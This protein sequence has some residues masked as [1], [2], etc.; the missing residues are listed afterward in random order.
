MNLRWLWFDH[1]PR[2]LIVPSEARWVAWRRPWKVRSKS[3]FL[4][5]TVWKSL[6]VYLTIAFAPFAIFLALPLGIALPDW[7][8]WPFL[9]AYCVSIPLAMYLSWLVNHALY[10]RVALCQLGY[11]CCVKC[12]YAH[13]GLSKDVKGCPECGTAREFGRCIHCN[14]EQDW[15]MSLD[16]KCTQ[17]GRSRLS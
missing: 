11:L 3:P 6:A 17:C 4:R 16:D 7:L 10:T 13:T 9:V 5:G 15:P 1:I 8:V 2:G 14:T 12:G